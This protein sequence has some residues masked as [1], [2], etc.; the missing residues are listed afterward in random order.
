LSVRAAGGTYVLRLEDLDG[1]RVRAGAAQRILDDLS[2]LGLDWDEGYDTGGPHAPYAQSARRAL[3]DAAFGRLHAAG[4]VYPCFCSR[5]DIQAAASAPQAPGDELPYPG[6]CRELDAAECARRLAAAAAAWRFRVPPDAVVAFED[7]AR[8]ATSG[9][10][11]TDFVVRRSDGT[12]AY[13]LAVVVDDA[14][15]QIDEVVRGDDLLASTPR[16]LLL[17]RALALRAP[18]FGHV[19]L[20][21]GEDG[22]RL[23][24][25]HAGTSLAELRA[26]GWSAAAVVG[27]LAAL[28]GLRPDPRPVSARALVDGFRLAGLPPRPGGLRI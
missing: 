1:P 5:K 18:R 9:P 15:M 25:R 7:L 11:P 20:L 12:A 21:L 16:Q 6:T 19:P 17:Y 4:A 14:A 10:A 22:V 28:L 3:Y 8:G 13:Q 27:R 24:K 23:S 2:W 26:A